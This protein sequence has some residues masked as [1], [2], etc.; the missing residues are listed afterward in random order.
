MTSLI[1][2]NGVYGAKVGGRQVFTLQGAA[3]MYR[4]FC[5]AC[6]REISQESCIVL[7]RAADDMMALGFTPAALEDIEIEVM[8]GLT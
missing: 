4:T 6:L 5:K 7:S 8:Q 1:C 2:K 3:D